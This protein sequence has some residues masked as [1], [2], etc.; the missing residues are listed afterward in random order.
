MNLYRSALVAL[1]LGALPLAAFAQDK[2]PPRGVNPAVGPKPGEVIQMPTPPAGEEQKA[3]SALTS[4]IA[5]FEA[6]KPNF[7]DM[8]GA[9]QD[10]AKQQSPALTAA[11]N[12]LGA[13][14]TLEYT[15]YDPHGVWK[16]RGQF[17]NGLADLMIGFGPN[18]KIQTLW[19]KPVAG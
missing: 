1:A 6:G 15:G 2:V 19:F 9:L 4:T 3:E 12:S 13:L 17:A 10:M 14:K 7:D 16:Y 5:A 18:G 8:E 11:F